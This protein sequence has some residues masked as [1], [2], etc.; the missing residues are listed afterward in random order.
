MKK[1]NINKVLMYVLKAVQ[2]AAIAFGLYAV[3]LMFS[4]NVREINNVIEELCD[5]LKEVWQ[6]GII[7][8]VVVIVYKDL[9][10]LVRKMKTKID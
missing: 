3:V 5:L 2:W 10:R 1:I 8:V 7:I 6:Y 4:D 9:D